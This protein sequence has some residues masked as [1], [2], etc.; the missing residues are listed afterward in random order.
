MEDMTR[1]R[2]ARPLSVARTRSGRPARTLGL[3]VLAG[4]ALLVAAS[5][6]AASG[7]GRSLHAHPAG[8]AA[9]GTYALNTLGGRPVPATARDTTIEDPW[10]R[11]SIHLAVVLTGGTV[12]LTSSGSYRVD[13]ACLVELNGK[14][15]SVQR[16]VDGGRYAVAGSVVTF[17]SSASGAVARGTLADGS[18][19]VAADLLGTEAVMLRCL[20]GECTDDVAAAPTP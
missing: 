12:T 4:M 10:G 14:A 2:S 9:S 20:A 8:G 18:L 17:T 15:F 1:T 3:R 7:S 11:G 19:T 13:A 16:C 6:L 5:A